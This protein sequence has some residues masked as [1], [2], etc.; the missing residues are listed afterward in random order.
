MSGLCSNALGFNEVPKRMLKGWGVGCPVLNLQ[1][2]LRVLE[3]PYNNETQAQL[4]Q[5]VTKQETLQQRMDNF[6]QIPGRSLPTEFGLFR[7][8]GS[9][10][11]ACVWTRGSLDPNS[12]LWQ[13]GFPDPGLA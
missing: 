4:T 11:A 13:R 2:R 1:E 7:E 5:V 10:G 8:N 3:M 6:I 9:G 12:F